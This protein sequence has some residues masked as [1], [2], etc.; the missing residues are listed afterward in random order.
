LFK[1]PRCPYR[2]CSQHISPSDKFYKRHGSY[3][4]LCRP[5]PI[6]RFRCKS[7]KRTFSRQ[8][9]RADYRDHR[10]NLNQKLFRLL[11]SGIG[12]RQSARALGLSL[13][14]TELK[15]RKLARHVRR[16]N[17]NLQNELPS[18]VSLQFDEF[19]TFEGRRNTRPL[20]VPVLIER[21]TRFVIW[22]ESAPIRPHGRMS[23][24]RLE[25]IE[26]EN[27]RLG[28]RRDTSARSVIRTMRR[29]ADLLEKNAVIA[30]ETD[31][32]TSYPGHARTAFG[33]Q[34]VIHSCTNSQLARMTWNPLFPI[35]HTE[36]ML[37]DL[38][39]RVRRRSWLASKKRR[40]L[41]LG[42]QLWIAYR[43]LVRRRFNFDAQSP[44]QLLG[45]V[46]RRLRIGELLSWRQ[47]WGRK[48][49]HPLSVRCV[50]VESWR[51]VGR[52]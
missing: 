42:L 20:S 30:L 16:L 7:C 39:G 22:A 48:S 28:P 26:N 10:P 24:S 38:L 40:Y 32:K 34:Q 46:N 29:G 14:C 11:T 2:H 43:N 9:F 25:A 23:R 5:H 31:E 13:R 3:H 21:S 50:S 18:H 17:L 19:E 41:D 1:P 37:R 35:N 45:A 49:I 12:L 4:A 6:P 33:E 27:E 47:D 36:A 8:S 51:P 52:A 15:F 44:A